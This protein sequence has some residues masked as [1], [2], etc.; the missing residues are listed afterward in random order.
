MHIYLLGIFCTALLLSA[1]AWLSAVE[2]SLFHLSKPV[3]DLLRERREKRAVLLLGLLERP[4]RLTMVVRTTIIAARV[5]VVCAAV[6]SAFRLASVQG[7]HP[8]GAV[9]VHVAVSLL[10]IIWFTEIGPR[11]YGLT[12]AESVGLAAAPALSSYVRLTNPLVELSVRVFRGAPA[13]IG[14]RPTIPYLTA[15]EII[16]V[17]KAG[18]EE[19]EIE[20]EER[21]MIYSIFELGD[22]AIRDVMLPRVDMVT[23]ERT[24]SV[25]EALDKITTHGH[26]RLPV[27]EGKID[28]IVG[29]LYAKDLLRKPA[30]DNLDILVEQVMREPFF[31]PEG[32]PVDDLLREFQRAKKHMA[33]VVDEY[34][35]TA[36]LVTM[37]DL[38]E[39]I[40]GEIEDEYD[41]DKALYQPLDE[42]TV[43]V[44]PKIAI[45]DL[46]DRFNITLPTDR[47]DTFGGYLYD[48]VDRVPDEGEV[49]KENGLLFTIEKV[50]R[51]R[52]ARVLIR[53]TGEAKNPPADDKA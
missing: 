24:R 11:A 20:E 47:H 1:T 50:N 40:V 25:R 17:V 48:V 34:G 45:D 31:V 44:N 19:G 4:R 26:S 30:L 23:V 53:K 21:E 15:E 5:G 52:I 46:N 10:L 42:E 8:V 6:W 28:K 36:G 12:H 33:I 14:L 2:S 18:E 13:W 32:K 43:A 3:Q 49:F 27:Y 35:G 39:E 37:E 9:V 7:V 22:T 51:Q 29:I 41:L 16:A 38:L